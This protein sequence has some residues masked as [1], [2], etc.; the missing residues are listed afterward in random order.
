MAT[1]APVIYDG[2]LSDWSDSERIDNAIESPPGYALYARPDGSSLAFAFHSAVPIGA[3]TTFWL[4]TDRDATT[5]YQIFGFAGG[6][7]YNVNIAADGTASLYTGAAGQT[8]VL[9][10]LQI[11][12]NADHTVA[13]FS[14]PKAAIGNPPAI[15]V[16]YDV[17]D[18]VFGPTSYS[19][20]PFTLFN[21]TGIAPNLST[22][23]GIVYSDTTAHQYFS[24]TA[25]AQLFMN[26]QAQAMQ[27]GVSFDLLSESD[28]T[29]LSKISQY[30]TL[31][32]P[33]FRNVQASQ[34]NA[35]ANTLQQ[36]EVQFGVGL[37]VGG[38]FM[39]DDENN[40]PLPGDSYS[41]MKLLLDATRVT[42][43]TGDVSLQAT[44]PGGLVLQNYA[45]NE[46]IRNYTGVGWNAFTNVSG[47]GTT[48]A[49]ETI[50]GQTYAAAMATQTGGRNVV[51]SSEATMA[52]S[53]LL[54][55]AIDYSAQ[56]TGVSVGLQLTR[57][58]GIVAARVDLDSSMYAEDV[59]P[60]DGSPGVYD[61]LVP[62][63]AQWKDA[64]NFVGS[65]YANIGNNPAQGIY[66]DWTVS[67][68]YYK[69]MIDLGNEIGTHSYTHP[70]NTNLLSAAQIQ[71]E[72]A[73]STTILNQ[74]LSAYLGHP[75]NIVGAA[76]PG[77]P[78]T[79]ATSTEIMKYVQQYL[80]GGYS[81]VGAG[82]PD[83]FGFLSP[84]Q[85]NKVYLAPNTSFDFT[86]VEFQGKTIAQAEAAW[87]QEWTDLT[88]KGQTP[89]VVWP[90]HDYAAAAF[91][92]N[93]TGTSPYTT[94]MFTDW[95]ARA[96]ASGSEFVTLAD[97]ADR[98]QAFDQASVTTSVVG[99]T[100]TATVGSSDA[101]RFA[102]DLQRQGSSV[103]QNVD[104][105][106]A[107]DTDSIFMPAS[108]GT[109]T[110][111][112][113][114]A[115][116]D[117]TH[118]AAL[119]MRASLISVA[120][121]G[122]N[123][124]FSVE[125]DGLVTVDLQNPGTDLINVTGATIASQSGEILTLNLGAAGHHDVTIGLGADSAPVITS[126]GGGD[127]AALSIPEHIAAVATVV[128]TDANAGDITTYGIASGVDASLF[129]IDSVT[130]VLSFK[131]AP[132]YT[133]PQDSDHNNSYLV[134][135]S[136]TDSHGLADLQQLTVN[137][138]NANVAPIITS[139]GAGATATLGIAEN[140]TA[141]TMVVATDAN[142]ATGDTTTYGIVSGADAA[143]FAIDPVT[144]VLTFKA[145]PDYELPQ[146]S[147][148]NNSYLV[149]ISA[150]DSRGLADLQNLTVNVTNV[151]GIVQTGTSG[152]DIMTGTIEPDTLSGAGGADTIS[153]L[154]GNDILNGNA[155][156]DII[157][158]GVGND[159]IT[160][161]A[162]ADTLTGGPGND[163][164]VYTDVADSGTT[165]TTRDV[166]TDFEHAIDRIDLSAIDANAGRGSLRGDQAFTFLPVAGTAFT[167]AAQLR[168]TY[169]TVG[170]VE[171][172]IVEGDVNVNHI[173][174][175]FSIDLVGHQILTASDFIL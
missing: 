89:I 119:P 53:N 168:Y 169:V 64:Y 105:W 158:G 144:G 173:G 82:Y 129:A 77:A 79:V 60:L 9:A 22:K 145:A 143:L 34:A 152:N 46:V 93:G 127:T 106:Y 155:G 5:G 100:I 116:D 52:D 39:T 118:I 10:N 134:N 164:F 21:D 170:G 132:D 124:A 88:S 86:L 8:L 103:I 115:Q 32:F 72:F 130:G 165:A 75:Y 172:T 159:R 121:D 112:L 56:G 30:D 76:V 63:L 45:S 135:V 67:L 61:K 3:N 2:D 19:D 35:I 18:A 23:V 26:A 113:G 68:P 167:G 140:T 137:V 102:L 59:N 48:V 6:A 131:V 84:T 36:A 55:Q 16:L 14:L 174:A 13:E 41:R 11:A 114:A 50:G 148:H 110:I 81:G 99:N 153:G 37:I 128:A 133:L 96:S 150:T 70:D 25:Y 163:L 12:Y 104:N 38:E 90:F 108:G 51:F 122:R 66:T 28:L 117:V 7:E 161:G 141:V 54:W 166:I 126:N 65:L 44:D 162:G 94:Q 136:A 43:G 149:N 107:Y 69:A 73:D 71:T 20:K 111:H 29:D 154:G 47:T 95:I 157:N 15:D 33:S 123:L 78:E 17:N 31:I 49:T 92:V 58:T 138:T 85:E 42:G 171:H 87:A 160:G 40:N 97:L 109:F 147:D 139:N 62:I 80:T 125:G 24:E 91:D 151:L 57:Q 120:G 27:A 142:R 156:K 175:D 1:S 4:N 146:D 83:A 98:I 101:G 74:Q